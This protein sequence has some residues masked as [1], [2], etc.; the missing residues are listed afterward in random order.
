VSLGKYSKQYYTVSLTQLYYY[1]LKSTCF[2]LDIEHH[3][4]KNIQLI[5]AGKTCNIQTST[6]FMWD[7][8]VR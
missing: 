3:Q 4:A 8:T 1:Y 6:C 7:P 2:G 5:Q